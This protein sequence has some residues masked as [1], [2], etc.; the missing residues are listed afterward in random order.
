MPVHMVVPDDDLSTR[1]M[2][3]LA[4]EAEGR[5]CVTTAPTPFGDLADLERLAP[6][7]IVLDFKFS[8]RE[9][10]WQSLQKLKLHRATMA[11]P[12]ILWTAALRDI[13]EQE[14][15]LKYK[16]IAVLYQLP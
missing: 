9:L 16:G 5:Y 1:E 4:P 8:G 15:I 13:Q 6:D 10:G 7:L 14:P 12:V 11:I 3:S 2:L